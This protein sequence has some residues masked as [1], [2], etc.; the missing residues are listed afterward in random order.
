MTTRPPNVEYPREVREAAFNLWLN[1]S[2]PSFRELKKLIK[3]QMGINVGLATI[4]KWKDMIPGWANAYVEEGRPGTKLDPAKIISALKNAKADAQALEADHFKGVKAQL[5]ARLYLSIKDLP[6]NS[7]EDWERAL[8]CCDRLEALI[9]AERGK[10]VTDKGQVGSLMQAMA[11][12]VNIAPF[13]KPNG[14]GA[15]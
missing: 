15:A 13:K 4:E 14:N 12:P 2:K 9:H 11:P 1:N 5:V 10:A 6:I 3:A 8:A 7:V